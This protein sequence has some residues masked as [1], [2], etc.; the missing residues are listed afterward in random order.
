MGRKELDAE[1]LEALLITDPEESAKAAGLRY[2]SDTDPGISRASVPSGFVYTGPDGRRIR[3]PRVLKRIASL[4]IPP[5]W[6]DVWICPSANGHLQATGRD[7]KGRKQYRYHPNWRQVRDETKYHR[8]ILFGELLPTIRSRCNDDLSLAGLPREKVLAA[9]VQLLERTLI[10]IGNEEY[11]RDN[12]SFGLTTMRNRHVDV[13]GSQIHFHF[14]GK[15]GRRHSVDITNRR[16]AAVVRRCRDLPG[17]SLFEYRSDDGTVHGIGSGDVNEYLRAVSGHDFTAKDFRTWAGT[18][19]AAA[20]LRRIGLS[21]SQTE[22]KKNIVQAIEEVARRLGNTPAVCRKCYVHPVVLD[23]YLEGTLA[24]CDDACAGEK[25]AS[26]DPFALTPGER[27]VIELL[28]A[29]LT[30]TR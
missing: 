17:H 8:M 22:A 13:L 6:T 26:S 29:Q 4:V 23:S 28:K 7:A 21:E 9:V 30:M 12:G 24:P 14:K 3:D 19:C 18:V 25:G 2:V 5:A 15:S 11:A 27:G 16:L 1:E 20:E 10:R